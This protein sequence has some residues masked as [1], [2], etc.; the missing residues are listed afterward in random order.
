LT[1]ELAFKNFRGF[2]G[3]DFVP[4]RP[5]TLLIGE[6]SAGKSSF[7]AG[8]KYILDFGSGQAEPSFNKD[9]FQLGT[10][11]QIAHVRGGQAGRARQFS[12]SLRT[13]VR[14]RRREQESRT[15]DFEITFTS[16]DSAAAVDRIR[17][18]VGEE[19]AIAAVESSRLA[20]TYV[21]AAG[22]PYVIEN[23]EVTYPRV[24]RSEFSRYWPLI[25][26]DIAFRMTRDRSR[27]QPSLI[28][29]RPEE[30]LSFLLEYAES[31]SSALRAPTIA[32]SPIRT[33]PLRTYT[34]GAEVRNSE[35]A[36]VPYDMAT[37]YRSP[38]KE[39][40]RKLKATIDGFGRASEMFTEL[41]IK[42]FG[43]SVS[44]PFQIQFSS[45]GPKANIVDLGY[46]TSQV[47][48][49]LHEVSSADR[50]SRFLIQQPEVHL[51]PRAQAAVGTFLAQSYIGE[52]KEFIIETHSDFIVDR[53]R[54]LIATG[55]LQKDEVS[56]LFFHRLKLENAIHPI[57]LDDAGSPID[58][59]PE[60]RAFFLGEQMRMLGVDD[61]VS[62]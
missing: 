18:K 30:R 27:E 45:G 42:S 10:F 29:R 22:S 62:D 5:L 59:P 16:A 46:G 4:V 33:K 9:P 13:E 49:L 54:N 1:Y 35:G 11:A 38:S 7:L 48:P 15:V 53:I 24:I 61:A 17:I 43:A 21:D 6:N 19:T 47:L 25:L 20:L 57:E 37:L 31:F 58:P 51:H 3:V 8:L 40:W 28:D 50:N 2:R 32:T 12:V 41:H 26:R 56:I 39:G 14:T 52:H 60:Y 23:S 55:K 36:H 34:P 44:D